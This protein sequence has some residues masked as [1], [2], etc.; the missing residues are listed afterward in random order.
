MKNRLDE[1]ID[2]SKTLTEFIK[3]GYELAEYQLIIKYMRDYLAIHSR[4]NGI[5]YNLG[6]T[7]LKTGETR[8]AKLEFRATLR[9]NP[10]FQPARDI[11]ER[12]RN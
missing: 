3:V 12:L 8:K 4:D 10:K 11:L 9:F 2:D 6:M 1:K 5:R 7:L